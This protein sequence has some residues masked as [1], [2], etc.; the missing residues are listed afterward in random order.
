M[1]L[2]LL[3]AS[4][5]TLSEVRSMLVAGLSADLQDNETQRLFRTRWP[6]LQT[7]AALNHGA[8]SCDL[9]L[10]RH[11]VSRED[12]AR[13]RVRYRAMGLSRSEIITALERHRRAA[14]QP[15]KPDGH[16]PR[17]IAD[18]VPEHARN[19]GPSLYLLHF[20]AGGRLTALPEAAPLELTAA[21][22]RA[23]PGTWLPEGR[24]VIVKP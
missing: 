2:S 10:Q 5:L 1:C 3:L 18:F 14:E 17:A 9:V 24:A 13:L 6:E 16:W 19:A 12:E 15:R 11:P 21:A 7:V 22:V 23:A 8:C 20:S 4:P